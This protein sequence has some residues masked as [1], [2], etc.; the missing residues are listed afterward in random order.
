MLAMAAAAMLVIR[1]G[2]E[3]AD[4][5]TTQA[6]AL[7]EARSTQPL[8]REPFAERGAGSRRIDRIASARAS[9][10]RDNRYA[11]WSVQ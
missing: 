1:P 6:V 10:L 9:D 4:S 5:S 8:F 3:R 2:L 7:H 11:R